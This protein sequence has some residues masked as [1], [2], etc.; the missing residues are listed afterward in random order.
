[1][2]N[3]VPKSLKSLVKDSSAG[4]DT[5]VLDETIKRATSLFQVRLADPD[6]MDANVAKR[7][8]DSITN[9]TSTV[10]EFMQA[11]TNYMK[12]AEMRRTNYRQVMTSFLEVY[13]A[14]LGIKQYGVLTVIEYILSDKFLLDTAITE[15]LGASK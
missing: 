7:V 5:A 13:T 11:V 8:K 3:K 2:Y 9:R 14:D 4:I 12:V 10:K 1:M 6:A 15:I